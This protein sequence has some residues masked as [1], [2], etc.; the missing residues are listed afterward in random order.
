MVKEEKMFNAYFRE[1]NPP[2][3]KLRRAKCKIENV[4]C[5]SGSYGR[6]GVGYDN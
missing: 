1:G 4:K 3:L 2:S 5:K 6:S